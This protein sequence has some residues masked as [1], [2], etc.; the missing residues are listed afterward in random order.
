[1]KESKTELPFVSIIVPV[2]N[3]E[4]FMAKCLDSLLKQSYPRD[5]YEVIVVDNNSD[6]QSALIARSFDGVKVFH[7]KKRGSYAARNFGISVARGHIIAFI[8]VDCIAA[9]NWLEQAARCLAARPCAGIVSGRVEFFSPEPL[10]VWGYFDR[11]TFLNLEHSARAGVSKTANMFV[12]RSLF[13]AIGLFD[14]DLLSGGDVE[15][16]ARAVTAGFALDYCP[17]AVVQHPVRN[18]LRAVAA[19]C[20]RVG[21]GKGQVLWKKRK[22]RDGAGATFGSNPIKH[23]FRLLH[24]SFCGEDRARS[25]FFP[26]QCAGAVIVLAII[27]LAGM[28]KGFLMH[29]FKEVGG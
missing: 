1:M 27:F 20:Y 17:G 3:G 28:V 22:C 18:T 21:L 10:S 14:G 16:T 9:G 11:N 13:D 7:E 23:S 25:A 19:K 29:P 12:R 26:V 2:Y 15:W 4:H 5:K 6:D 8:D 24:R